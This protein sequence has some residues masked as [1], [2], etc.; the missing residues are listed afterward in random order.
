[1]VDYVLTGQLL[2]DIAGRCQ[3]LRGLVKKRGPVPPEPED[4]WPDRL[5][6]QG[7]SFDSLEG[8]SGDD[9][10]DGGAGSDT[11]PPGAL[12]EGQEV[13]GADLAVRPSEVLVRA[14]S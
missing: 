9:T 4:F 8:G 5:R 2:D 10:L 13:A 1:M 11:L 12:V 14:G 3:D 6:G 7:S